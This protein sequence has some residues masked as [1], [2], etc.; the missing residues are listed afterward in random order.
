MHVSRHKRSR[1]SPQLYTLRSLE[2]QDYD[3]VQMALGAL[4]EDKRLR[5]DVRVVA[6]RLHE[7]MC[8]R[9]RD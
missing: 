9:R 6:D 3:V 2:Q 8:T 4:A 1:R 7:E 5:M